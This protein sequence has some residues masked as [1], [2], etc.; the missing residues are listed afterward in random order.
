MLIVPHAGKYI[1]HVL[2]V[3]ITGVIVHLFVSHHQCSHLEKVLKYF[4][5]V[6]G[7]CNVAEVGCHSDTGTEVQPIYPRVG[8]IVVASITNEIS[9]H[10]MHRSVVIMRR[11][12]G[13]I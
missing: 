10:L 8:Y 13:G 2:R 4:K 11:I 12:K 1:L 5:V 6:Y 3:Y 9:M 7:I